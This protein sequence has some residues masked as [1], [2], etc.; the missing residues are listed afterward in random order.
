LKYFFI[1]RYMFVEMRFCTVNRNI[2]TK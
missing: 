2:V 1:A